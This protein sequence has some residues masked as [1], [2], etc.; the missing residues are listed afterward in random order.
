MILGS[1]VM[2]FAR[3]IY[4]FMDP[5]IAEF[6]DFPGFNINKMI[7]LAAM[8]GS[9]KLCNVF[10]ELMFDDQVAIEQQFNGII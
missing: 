8:V 7:V 6:N 9:F 1:E 4:N 3:R 10:A 2:Q 5:W